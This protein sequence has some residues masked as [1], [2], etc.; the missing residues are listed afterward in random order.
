M[1]KMK[2]ARRI[3]LIPIIMLGVSAGGFAADAPATKESVAAPAK[4][5][6]AQS[7]KKTKKATPRKFTGNISALDN[8]TGAVAVKGSSDEKNFMTKDAAK[9]ALE[10][11]TVGDRVRVVYSEKDGKAVA[12]SVRRLKLPQSKSKTTAPNAKTTTTDEQKETKEKPKPGT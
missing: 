4:K 5:T 11:L 2:W 12:T 7:T 10:R 1:M 6:G 3:L 9:D 8:K